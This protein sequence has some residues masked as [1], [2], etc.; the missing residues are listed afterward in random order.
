MLSSLFEEETMSTTVTSR[1]RVP[2]PKQLS[3]VNVKRDEFETFW[4]ILMTYCQQDAGYMEFF[5]GGLYENWEPLSLNPTRGITVKPEPEEIAQDQAAAI[6]NATS[7]SVAVRT[8]LNSLLTTI[9]AYCPDGLFKTILTD[10]TSIAWIRKRLTQVCNIDTSGRHLPKILNIKYN[11]DEESPA[12]FMERIKSSFMDSLMPAK[13]KYHGSE[14]ATPETLSPTLESIIVIQCLKAIHPDLPEFI[15]NN[16]GMLFPKSTPNFCDIQ[17]ELCETMDTIL[18]Q[19]EAHENINRLNTI[20]STETLRWA[21][22][23]PRGKPFLRRGPQGR[24]GNAPKSTFPQRRP[25]QQQLSCDY[26]IALGKDEKIWATHDKLNCYDL[27]PE[28]RRTRV[29]ARMLS[30]PVMTDENEEWDLQEALNMVENQFYS[31]TT[32]SDD[33]DN[34]PSQ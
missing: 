27:F 8:S 33:T 11:R 4:H 1:A 28:K 13:T 19:M 16:K 20:E 12:A 18:A 15:M 30:V 31:Q 26:C 17:Q 24:P 23:V 10:S 2:T 32:I 22:S 14:L 25:Q 6:R 3:S 34:L 9:A 7:K 29:N 21:N 5:Q